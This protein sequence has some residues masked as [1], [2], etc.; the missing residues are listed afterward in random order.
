[1]TYIGNLAFGN[2][3]SLSSIIVAEGN[4]VYKSA[5][6]CLIE[7]ATRTL[8]LG[9]KT[10]IIPKDGSVKTIASSAFY[11]SGLL[12]SITI[13][14]GV[15]SIGNWTFFQCFSLRSITIPVTVSKIGEWLF[16]E[17]YNLTDIY[18]NGTKAEW[19]KIS[20]GNDWYTYTGNFKV[21]CTD[22][23]INK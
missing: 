4:A 23:I 2:C 17:C 6:N 5:G 22:G 8:V 12:E 21:T 7:K 20:K 16:R 10:S 18:Y 1:M 13:P 11:G 3:E 15:K 9:C 14:N 19:D